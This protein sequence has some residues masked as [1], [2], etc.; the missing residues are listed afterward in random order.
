MPILKILPT[1]STMLVSLRL[2]EED[3]IT[4]LAFVFDCTKGL[5]GV[6]VQKR[7]III[8]R[9][10]KRPALLHRSELYIRNSLINKLLLIGIY[11]VKKNNIDISAIVVKYK[12][13]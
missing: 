10:M 13:F 4:R 2:F 12:N 6:F 5:L 1:V 11:F 7:I 3:F 8:E 9:E